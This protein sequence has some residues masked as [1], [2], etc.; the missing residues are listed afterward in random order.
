MKRGTSLYVEG[1]L[2]KTTEEA[3]YYKLSA[4]I[5]IALRNLIQLELETSR[6][7]RSKSGRSS[8]ELAIRR[9]KSSKFIERRLEIPGVDCLPWPINVWSLGAKLPIIKD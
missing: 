9:R 5:R 4:S 3:R 7:L 2:S 6:M 1:K 8:S